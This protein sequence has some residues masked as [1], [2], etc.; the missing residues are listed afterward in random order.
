MTNKDKSTQ[1]I[2]YI[3]L[4]FLLLLCL[5]K[6]PYGYYQFVR[7][8]AFAGF[9]YSAYLQYKDNNTDKMILFIVLALLFQPLL[10]IALGRVIWNIMD[11]VVSSYLIYT[12]VKMHIKK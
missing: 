2:I 4:A 11:V 12:L 5:A 6:M 9:G 3:A 10:P 7:F 8:L 1:T